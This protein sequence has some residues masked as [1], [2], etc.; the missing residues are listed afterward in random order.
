MKNE[1]VASENVEQSQETVEPT[2]VVSRDQI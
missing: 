1:D 2:Q